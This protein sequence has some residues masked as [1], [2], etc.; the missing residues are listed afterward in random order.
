MDETRVKLTVWKGLLQPL[1]N[2]YRHCE[3]QKC[4]QPPLD[5]AYWKRQFGQAGWWE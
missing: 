5:S 3:Q 2:W 4:M 1:Q